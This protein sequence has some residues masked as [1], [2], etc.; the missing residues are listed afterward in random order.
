M[1]LDQ[2]DAIAQN[3][4]FVFG[5]NLLGHDFPVLKATSPWM[6]LLQKPAIDKIEI[7]TSNAI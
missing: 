4:D 2:L 6:K 7:S 1:V 3:A 5:H